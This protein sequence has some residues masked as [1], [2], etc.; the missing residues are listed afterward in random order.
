M[1]YIF[2]IDQK[3]FQVLHELNIHRCAKIHNPKANKME[4]S[5]VLQ[6]YLPIRQKEEYRCS[7]PQKHIGIKEN[8]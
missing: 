4:R 7:R 2:S 8:I 1:L 3:S 5:E 6:Y